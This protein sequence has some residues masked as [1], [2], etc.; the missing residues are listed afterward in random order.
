MS[1]VWRSSTYS[2][3]TKLKLYHSCILTTLLYSSECWR[4]TEKGLTKLSTIHTKSLRRILRTF[5][6]KTISNKDL[7]ERC[8]TESMAEKALE[9]D[10]PCQP[11]RGLLRQDCLALDTRGKG[12]EGSSKDHMATDGG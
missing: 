10:W 7:L 2:I 6:P 11:P 8:G 4:L 12:K 1:K 5:W 9:V 3:H